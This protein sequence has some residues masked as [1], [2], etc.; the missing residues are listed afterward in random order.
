MFHLPYGVVEQSTFNRFSNHSLRATAATV[1]F[2]ANVPEKIVQQSTGH[3]SLKGS[4]LYECVSKKPQKGVSSIL[5]GQVAMPQQQRSS[6]SSQVTVP[7]K[8]LKSPVS[9]STTSEVAISS[10]FG[11]IANCQVSVQ[12]FTGPVANASFMEGIN[13]IPH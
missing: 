12:V 10:F 8:Q 11:S 5:F 2:E 1:L 13:S 7:Q 6:P 9:Y 3:R 4:R